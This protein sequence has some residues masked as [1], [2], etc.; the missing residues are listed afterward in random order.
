MAFRPCPL[1]FLILLL[2]VLAILLLSALLVL[3]RLGRLLNTDRPRLC[4]APAFLFP[5]RC[6]SVQ[7]KTHASN[8][9]RSR[10]ARS[11]PTA[12]D[13]RRSSC[14]TFARAERVELFAKTPLAPAPATTADRGDWR[15]DRSVGARF[16]LPLIVAACQGR[17][18]R[19]GRVGSGRVG[20]GDGRG[21]VVRIV[22]FWAGLGLAFRDNRKKRE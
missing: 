13:R 15:V 16:V 10:I 1:D 3:V 8:R 4:P 9:R 20:R 14:R 11:A 19:L 5:L 12:D 22:H 2:V 21:R 6:A 7:S 18:A 17:R